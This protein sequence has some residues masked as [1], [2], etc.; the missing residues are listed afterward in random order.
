MKATRIPSMR[1]ML[2]AGFLGIAGSAAA[3][4]QNATAISTGWLMQD[5]A[6]VTQSGEAIS[7]VGFAPRIFKVRPYVAPPAASA[8]PPAAKEPDKVRFYNAPRVQGQMAWPADPEMNRP[9]HSSKWVQAPGPP[10]TD[11]Y[12]ATVPGT[13]LTTLVNNKA[14]QKKSWV[15]SGSGSL[16]SE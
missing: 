9:S 3:M 5:V 1:I 13:V 14:R 11:W 7:K 2:L 10:S 12:R 8:N 16:P 4:E 6:R 15:D